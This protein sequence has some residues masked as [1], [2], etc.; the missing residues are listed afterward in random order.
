MKY[1][2]PKEFYCKCGKC[3]KGIESMQ[4]DF[5][6][7]LVEV[8]EF[9]DTPFAIMSS[10]RCK[11][12]NEAVGG[13]S[14]SAHMTGNAV[15]ISCTDSARRFKIISAAIRCGI[16]RIGIAKNFIHLDNHPSLPQGVIWDYR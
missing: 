15:D 11:A 16:K 4:P 9:A 8:R 10:I 6:V 2:K 13:A 1:F 5:L 3:G 7:L 12:H 14:G